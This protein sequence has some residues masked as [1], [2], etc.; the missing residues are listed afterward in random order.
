MM[1][2]TPQQAIPRLPPAIPR[3]GYSKI[4]RMVNQVDLSLATG[5]FLELELTEAVFSSSMKL[6]AS[7]LSISQLD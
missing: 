6:Q 4:T 5:G 7:V 1:R 2:N 3:L